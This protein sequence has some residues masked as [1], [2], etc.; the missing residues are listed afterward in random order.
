MNDGD[1]APVFFGNLEIQ[2]AIANN[3]DKQFEST[4]VEQEWQKQYYLDE[5]DSSLFEDMKTGVYKLYNF[6]SSDLKNRLIDSSIAK[7]TVG[8][9]TVQYWLWS[10][11]VN[12]YYSKYSGQ[13]IELSGQKFKL[14]TMSNEIR[15]ELISLYAC[16]LQT[17]V[18]GAIKH[19]EGGSNSYQKFLLEQIAVNSNKNFILNSLKNEY[20]FIYPNG[21][22][23]PEN[24]LKN[25]II[26]MLFYVSALFSKTR[27][28]LFSSF[29]A[30]YSLYNGGKIPTIDISDETKKTVFYNII[31][32]IDEWRSKCKDSTTNTSVVIEDPF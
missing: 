24:N 2:N 28:D 21:K 23:D 16:I 7:T 27:L 19:I 11:A 13:I 30:V 1:L 20:K 9:G 31:N 12:L 14:K 5:S 18:I 29:G 10:D 4:F 22:N 32:V 3:Y 6:T 17:S 15:K 26:N 8:V 25:E